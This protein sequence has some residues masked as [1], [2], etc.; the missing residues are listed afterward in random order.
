MAQLGAY[1]GPGCEARTKYEKVSFVSAAL[2]VVDPAE[3]ITTLELSDIVI[4]SGRDGRF[5]GRSGGLTI[6]VGAGEMVALSGP[7]GFGGTTLARVIAGHLAP[8]SGQ[9]KVDGR[10]FTA[11]AA[12]ARPVG[13]VPVDGGLLPQL[14]L[15]EN[16]TYGPRLADDANE[17]M[18]HRLER[19]V[20]RLELLPS[21]ALRPYEVSAGQRIRA[22]LAR[23]AMR[24]VPSQVLVLDAT[25]GARGVTGVRRLITRVWGEPATV[26][27]LLLTCDSEVAEQADRLIWVEDGRCAVDGTI[28]SLRV[29]PP[30]LA[31]AELVVAGPLA[32]VTAVVRDGE[33]DLGGL[34]LPLLCPDG[35]RVTVLLRAES[36]EIV[37]HPDEEPTARVLTASWHEGAVQM[38]VEPFERPGDRWPA[39][40]L[41]RRHPRPHDR[42]VLRLRQDR[43][44]VFDA[45]TET[46]VGAKA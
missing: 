15:A 45:E 3:V 37:P 20:K 41:L 39:R 27:V 40:S 12:A 42:V 26:A 32:K 21:L 35:R 4:G 31:I 13:F 17:I 16:I 6:G 36:L 5:S 33:A 24:R 14:T 11:A 8:L 10:D 1:P 30:S 34:K 38:V 19:L 23:V 43:V 44:L 18:R 7:P 22:A 29:A 25:A 2:T 28:T 46:P 9:I